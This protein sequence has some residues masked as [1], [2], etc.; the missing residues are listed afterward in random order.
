MDS[1]MHQDLLKIWTQR[2]KNATLDEQHC[3]E[4]ILG[5][6]NVRSLDWI[7]LISILHKISDPQTVYEFFAMDD[8]KG[9]DPKIYVELF[10][11]DAEDARGK[12]VRAVRLLYRHEVYKGMYVEYVR[13]Q[14]AD[15][16]EWRRQQ[17]DETKKKRPAE[18]DARDAKKMAT[19]N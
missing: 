19:E 5:R 6:D 7:K 14:E 3:V 18:K 8:Y 12:H 9:D 17:L 2:S 10:H 13:G 11:Y 4:R 15:M 1:N 16:A